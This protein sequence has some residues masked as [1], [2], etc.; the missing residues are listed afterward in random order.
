LTA[1]LF[2][3]RAALTPKATDRETVW[4]KYLAKK[5]GGL[6]EYVLPD[7]SRVDI[8][9][10]TLAIEV[11]W[12]KK[13]PQAIGQAVYYGIATDRMPAVLLLLRGKDTEIKYL[14]RA[15]TAADNLNIPVFT[16]QTNPSEAI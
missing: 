3:R 7:R 11:D 16:W 15:R 2:L 4:S 6:A 8:L 12:A 5:M 1:L 13:W 10:P 9:T 14:R